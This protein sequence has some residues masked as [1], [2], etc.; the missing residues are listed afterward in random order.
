MQFNQLLLTLAAPAAARTIEAT[1]RVVQELGSSFSQLLHAPPPTEGIESLETAHSQLHRIAG[2]L[3]EKLRQAG[4][5]FPFRLRVQTTEYG[6]LEIGTGGVGGPEL[7]ATLEENPTML[8]DFRKLVTQ[9]A[10]LHR[11][12]A[13]EP[14][15]MVAVEVSDVGAHF[16]VRH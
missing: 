1:S 9:L 11:P 3:R 5:P 8:T 10:E 15:P 4:V 13:T 2:K 6:D 16:W 14:P 7:K 12:A